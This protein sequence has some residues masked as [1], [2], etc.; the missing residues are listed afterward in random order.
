MSTDLD[1]GLDGLSP[2]DE[3]SADLQ[4]NTWEGDYRLLAQHD[5]GERSFLLTFDTAATW[6]YLPGAPSLAAFDIVR[7]RQQGT[8]SMQASKHAVLAFSQKWLI[9]RGCPPSATVPAGFLPADDLTVLIT[10]RI[11]RSGDRYGVFD[12]QVMDG[13]P[14][15]WTMAVDRAAT[16][17]PVRLFLEEIQPDH[18]TYT[19]REGAFPDLDAAEEWLENRPTPL[20]PAPEDLGAEARRAHAALARS[21]TVTP[22][23]VVAPAP[24]A[25]AAQP[26][27]QRSM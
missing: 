25:P 12:H 19:V 15:A 13:T 10:E 4:R 16:E 20:P 3:H 22:T 26:V 23:P 8:F 2:V 24:A 27:V 21:G 14:E 9:E 7:D 6:D 18:H 5:V 11:S 1:F 17:L